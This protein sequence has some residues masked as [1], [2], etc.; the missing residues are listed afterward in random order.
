MEKLALPVC[1]VS[2]LNG[3]PSLSSHLLRKHPGCDR[4]TRFH[5]GGILVCGEACGLLHLTIL[6]SEHL[7]DI[8]GSHGCKNWKWLPVVLRGPMEWPQAGATSKGSGTGSKRLQC[9]D[10]I[11]ILDNHPWIFDSRLCPGTNLPLIQ[12]A[13]C[14]FCWVVC[15]LFSL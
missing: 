1:F 3:A 11:Y 15:L 9:Q 12:R 6:V 7:V 10:H 4:K 2:A 5:P 14:F 13:H 8:T